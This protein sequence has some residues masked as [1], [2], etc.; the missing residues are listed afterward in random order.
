MD[1]D[2]NERRTNGVGRRAADLRRCPFHASH[3]AQLLDLGKDMKNKISLKMLTLI[4]SAM[5]AV[6]TLAFA[7]YAKYVDT[8]T[9]HAVVLLKEHVEKSEIEL[10]KMSDSLHRME[11]T[12]NL[13]N[14]RL[15]QLDK[16]PGPSDYRGAKPEL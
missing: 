3:E 14:Y 1:W 4:M 8:Q 2:G 16:K 13:M 10:G 9:T 11:V 7:V 6:A 15:D 12:I 5:I